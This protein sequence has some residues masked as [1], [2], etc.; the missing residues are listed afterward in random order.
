MANHLAPQVRVNKNGVAV[1]KHVRATPTAP[2]AR[3]GVPAPG[4]AVVVTEPSVSHAERLQ[5]VLI[6]ISTS[7]DASYFDAS[8]RNPADDSILVILE[9]VSRILGQG[10][11]DKSF[12]KALRAI[13]RMAT[14][15][16]VEKHLRAAVV[17]KGAVRPDLMMRVIA[18]LENSEMLRPYADRLNEAPPE[19][20]GKARVVATAISVLSSVG[21]YGYNSGAKKFFITHPKL[22]AAI[23]ASPERAKEYA[24]FCAA[25][26]SADALDEIDSIQSAVRSG[27]L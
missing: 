1:T 2:A 7:A 18:G 14:P 16:L 11:E 27:L 25:R 19:V 10:L 24:D 3:R 4:I 21:N 15:E 5:Q 20:Q 6:D 22:E 13:V 12:R 26:G 9:D 8:I 17:L 23:L